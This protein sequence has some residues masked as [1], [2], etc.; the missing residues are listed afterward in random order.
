MNS[1]VFAITKR[2]R[3]PYIGSS[4]GCAGLTPQLFSTE[5]EAADICERLDE[6]NPVGFCVMSVALNISPEDANKLVSGDFPQGWYELHE[7]IVGHKI[8]TRQG[9]RLT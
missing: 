3:S 7:H 8:L 2:G 4:W 6:V 9:K 1:T 5:K